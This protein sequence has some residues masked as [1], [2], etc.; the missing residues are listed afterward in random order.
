MERFSKPRTHLPIRSWAFFNPLVIS[1]FYT[2]N[3]QKTRPRLLSNAKHERYT[4]HLRI[5][6]TCYCDFTM[7]CTSQS[8]FRRVGFMKLGFHVL[9]AKHTR[10]DCRHSS[11][12]RWQRVANR[13]RRRKPIPTR[14]RKNTQIHANI[15]RTTLDR[16]RVG[17][18]R[19]RT[20]CC[21]TM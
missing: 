16:V 7:Y 21:R 14:S 8:V 15:C 11:Y 5:G 4:T 20:T 3:T 1:T 12:V 6:Y 18:S 17:V 2:L 13:L 10:V 19:P 9:C